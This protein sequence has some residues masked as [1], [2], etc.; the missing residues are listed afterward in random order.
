MRIALAM[1]VAAA[2][3]FDRRTARTIELLVISVRCRRAAGL[4]ALLC[5]RY[6]GGRAL[7]SDL[8]ELPPDAMWSRFDGL[9]L[10]VATG[11]VFAC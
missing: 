8:R 5:G 6:S 2:A 10:V 9:V 11:E 4:P 3:D 1:T 7:L